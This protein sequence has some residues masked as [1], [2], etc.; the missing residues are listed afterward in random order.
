MGGRM[1]N[2]E[3]ATQFGRLVY[4]FDASDRAFTDIKASA[5][6]AMSKLF[7]FDDESD[8]IIASSF[9]DPICDKIVTHVLVEMGKRPKYLAWSRARV[10]GEWTNDTGHYI[11]SPVGETVA[12]IFDGEPQPQ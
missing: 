4:I 11:E 8:Y 10:N 5:R 7:D 2:F 3:P 9:G 12:E 6:K 1:P